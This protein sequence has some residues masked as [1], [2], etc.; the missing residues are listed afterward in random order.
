MENFPALGCFITSLQPV[1]SATGRIEI[2]SVSG[3]RLVC[4]FL[5]SLFLS[6]CWEDAL[7]EQL[8]LSPLRDVT[9]FSNSLNG[10]S[11]AGDLFAGL[12]NAGSR[13]RALLA[14]DL[15][16]IPAGATI[17]GVSLQLTVTR[18][19]G[20]G[21]LIDVHKLLADWGEGSST[22]SG[23]GGGQPG[24]ATTNDATWQFRFFNTSSWMTN[25]G[26]F[27]ALSSASASVGSSGSPVWSGAGL[28]ADVQ[29]WMDSPINNFGWILVGNEQRSQSVRAF[30]SRESGSGVPSLLVDYTPAAPMT[31]S[32]HETPA[33]GSIQSGVGLIRGWACDA[34]QV[35]ISINGGA[36]IPIGYGTS[37]A[38]T[39]GI[40]GDADNGYGMVIAWGL[41]GSGTHR[42]Q[43]F[44]DDIEVADVEFEVVAIGSGF[45]LGLM[46]EYVLADFPAAADLTRVTWSEPD[47]NFRISGVDLGGGFGDVGMNFTSESETGTFPDAEDLVGGARHESPAQFSIQSGVGLIRG[48]ACDAQQVAISINGGALI[49]I[50]Y[51]TSRA[52]TQGICGDADNGY[53]MVIAWGLLGSGVHRLQTFIDTVEIADIEFEVV[54]IGSGFELGLQGTYN[55]SAFPE[56]GQSVDVQWSEPDQNFKVIRLNP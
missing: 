4:A 23:G 53:G 54:A 16:A 2:K 24:A 19:R 28:V 11:A 37:R 29:S 51:G 12:N 7:A 1:G 52:D 40:C 30:S 21:M 38:D 20:G 50:G 3:S 31:E 48:W 44:V 15:S 32:N 43:T 14:F 9:I 42:L 8:L 45:E 18:G 25:G 49:P 35:A 46:G 41:L 22:G 5:L 34:Q 27:A 17:D 55:L 6:I 56:P 36:L 47:Q 39:Q 33:Q 13:R 10:S 26:D